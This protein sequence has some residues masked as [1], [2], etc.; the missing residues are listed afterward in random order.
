MPTKSSSVHIGSAV[1]QSNLRSGELIWAEVMF[2]LLQ[3]RDHFAFHCLLAMLNVSCSHFLILSCNHGLLI[4]FD[5]G[6]GYF[7]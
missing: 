1:V 4:F 5:D 6:G 7:L 2:K 3:K